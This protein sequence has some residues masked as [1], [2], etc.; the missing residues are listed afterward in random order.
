MA[1][2]STYIT[3][4]C[5]RRHSLTLALATA[6]FGRTIMVVANCWTPRY[7]RGGSRSDCDYGMWK[8]SRQQPWCDLWTVIIRGVKLYVCVCET[9][10]V[11]V[12]EIVQMS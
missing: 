6:R 2:D 11:W 10:G 12:W 3:L 8:E 7:A 1:Q 4:T 5:T 9:R